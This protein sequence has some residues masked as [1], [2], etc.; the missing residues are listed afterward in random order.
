MEV[1]L[2]CSS[3]EQ[4]LEDYGELCFKVML[5]DLNLTKSNMIDMTVRGK[6][7]MFKQ[8]DK[9]R[10]EFY[11]VL[12]NYKEIDLLAAVVITGAVVLTGADVLTGVVVITG[13]VI[14][15]WSYRSY[16]CCRLLG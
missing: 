12:L 6:K 7:L 9:D 1:R 14:S 16:W 10:Y 8:L 13:A 5:A 15:S 11:Q 2:L 4:P 3:S